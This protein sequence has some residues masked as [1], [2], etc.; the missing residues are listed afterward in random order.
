MNNM[1]V[2]ESRKYRDMNQ[3]IKERYWVED[4]KPL[5]QTE[6][7]KKVEWKKEG[8]NEEEEKKLITR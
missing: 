5:K 1:R 2:K 7:N 4:E 6:Q 8:E 3:Q